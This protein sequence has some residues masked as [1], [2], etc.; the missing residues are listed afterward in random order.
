MTTPIGKLKN[1]IGSLVSIITL[2]VLALAPTR[3]EAQQNEMGTIRFQMTEV[4][5]KGRKR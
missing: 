4:C 2:T 1:V 3:L 5:T